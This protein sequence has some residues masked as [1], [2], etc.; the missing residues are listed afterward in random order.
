MSETRMFT[1]CDSTHSD[2]NFVVGGHIWMLTGDKVHH[3]IMF[4]NF[5]I[6]FV[7][8]LLRFNASWAQPKRVYV[9][10]G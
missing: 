7:W 2:V 10:T 9:N 1:T 8:Q 4:I 6:V 5:I 3:C